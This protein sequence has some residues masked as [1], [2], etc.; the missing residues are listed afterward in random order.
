MGMM[1]M[2]TVD[3]LLQSLKKILKP[4]GRFVFS[5]PHPC[6]TSPGSKLTAELSSDAGKM[7]Q[8]FGLFIQNYIECTTELSSG[9]T[10]QPRPHYLFHRPLSAI[11]KSCFDAGW[12]MDGLEEPVFPEN[13]G[14]KNPFSWN[15]RPRIPPVIV[16]RL[17][18]A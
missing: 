4:Q 17:R 13:G 16:I 12:R 2:P 11:L 14:G 9:L 15:K 3:P 1:D 5:L 7:R 8:I 6:F 10:N 18:P